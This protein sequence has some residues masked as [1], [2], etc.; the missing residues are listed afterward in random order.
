MPGLRLVWLA[1]VGS[2]LRAAAD[3]SS[4]PPALLLF[5]HIEKTGGT[6]IRDW[7]Q[8]RV[9]AGELDLFVPYMFASCY[10]LSRFADELGA[11]KPRS[12][13]RSHLEKCGVRRRVD[14]RL[15]RLCKRNGCVVGRAGVNVSEV[16]WRAARVAVEFHGDGPLRLFA[17]QLLP[18]VASLRWR[19][20]EHAVGLGL[21]LLARLTRALT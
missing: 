11:R 15:D 19:C 21:R 12:Q 13:L 2:S 14:G 7:L 10:V 5:G 8:K 9:A 4:R 17:S 3:A 1:A 20:V 6:S 18:N 16:D